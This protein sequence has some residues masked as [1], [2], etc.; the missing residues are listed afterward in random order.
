MVKLLSGIEAD[1]NKANDNGQTPLFIASYNGD[2]EVVK[3][4]AESG[5]DIN[6]AR[7]GQT[8]LYA[9]SWI[10]HAEVVKVLAESGADINKA[11]GDGETP[12]YIAS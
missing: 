11:N 7:Y 6:K 9:A 5:A 1:T 8:P 2:V 3:V 4:L 10:G 12:L